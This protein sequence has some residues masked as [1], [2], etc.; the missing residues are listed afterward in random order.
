MIIRTMRHDVTYIVTETYKTTGPIR[1]AVLP[2]SFRRD[3][4]AARRKTHIAGKVCNGR[5]LA[6]VFVISRVEITYP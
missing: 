1:P 3:R 4:P 5:Q 2:E 6:I